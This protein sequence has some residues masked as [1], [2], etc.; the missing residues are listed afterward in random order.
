MLVLSYHMST[1]SQHH[2][3][4]APRPV[5]TNTAAGCGI[6]LRAGMALDPGWPNPP[7]TRDN[8]VVLPWKL[9]VAGSVSR[10]EIE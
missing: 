9:R 6:F 7:T 8:F 2:D 10:R 3:P 1:L 5:R 4:A